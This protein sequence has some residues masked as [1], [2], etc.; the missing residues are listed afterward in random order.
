M[1]LRF[2]NICIIAIN[3]MDDCLKEGDNYEY[4]RIKADDL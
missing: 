3:K 1:Q 2:R 4:A